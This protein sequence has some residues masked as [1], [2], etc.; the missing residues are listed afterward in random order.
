MCTRRVRRSVVAIVAG[1][2]Y[3]YYYYYYYAAFNAPCVSHKYDESSF[4]AS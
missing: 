2:H 3:Y 4:A 1:F